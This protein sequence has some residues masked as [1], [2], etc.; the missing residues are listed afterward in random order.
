MKIFISH[1]SANKDYGNALVELLRGIGITEDEIVFTSNTAY[2]IPI[3][4]NIFNWLKSQITEKPFVIY[5]LSKE[6][7]SS[8]ACLNEMGAAWV[9]ENEHAM[10][11]TPNFDLSSKEFREGAIDPREIGFYIN[12]EERLLSFIQHLEA[13]F[14][15][16]KKSVIINQ[17]VK[18][19]LSEIESI[20]RESSKAT[21]LLK[22]PTTD[23][24]KE[25][26]VKTPVINENNIEKTAIELKREIEN[27]DDLYSKFLNDI[28]SGKLKDEE[29]ILI[30]YLNDTGRGKLMIGWQEHIE[31]NNIK[32]W[33][34]IKE[35]D[36]ILSNK[37][38]SAVRKIGLRGFTEVSAVTSGGNAK[39]VKL[40]A[41]IESNIIDLPK[42]ILD[43]ITSY[44]KKI[45]AKPKKDLWEDEGLPF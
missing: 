45:P 38:E 22:L 9:I 36:N 41:E 19:Y 11:F 2:G 4:Q 18:K 32:D 16:S 34:D 6:Y 26:E 28:L 13:Y 21:N 24:P 31:V 15:I 35:I 30:H 10:L 27:N 14:N 1:S 29:L 25:V 17:K 7:Y 5:L 39:E 3:G 20:V 44:L 37:Y 42:E 40:K 23:K 43:F 8:I 12:D 33:E